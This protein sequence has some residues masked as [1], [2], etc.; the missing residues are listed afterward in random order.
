MEIA[1]F[2][3]NLLQ[4]H[5]VFLASPDSLS[6]RSCPCVNGCS[7]AGRFVAE[8]CKNVMKQFITVC[9][10]ITVELMSVA[11]L[12]IRWT[13]CDRHQALPLVPGARNPYFGL[14]AKPRE[15]HCPSCDSIVY[16]RCHSLCG[17][18]G[19]SLPEAC[20]FTAAEAENVKML[21]RT[22]R[23]RHR[24]WLKKTTAL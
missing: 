18:C 19:Q 12:S 11:T 17:V 13:D 6:F 2:L 8:H 4:K 20:L 15:R 3:T 21:L 7:E 24:A 10:L 14:K 5:Y 23:Q 22:E 1:S 9:V 16:S